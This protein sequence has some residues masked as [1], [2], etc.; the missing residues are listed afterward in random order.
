MTTSDQISSNYL[1]DLGS[2]LKERAV[3]AKAEKYIQENELDRAYHTGY[4]M[5]MH[6]VIGIMQHQADAFG[7]LRTALCLDD[8]EPDKDLL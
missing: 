7:M 6:D 1:Y 5:A 4:L 8:I 3:E 2:L